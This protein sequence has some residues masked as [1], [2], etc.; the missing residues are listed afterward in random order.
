VAALFAVMTKV[1]AYAV[2][3]VYTLIFP[4][5]TPSTGTMFVDLLLP[6]AL[7][8]LVVGAVGVLG[9]KSLG[10]LVALG[11]GG[12]DGHAVHRGLAVHAD[13]HDGGA[14]LP[15]AF[16]AGDGALF[17][18]ADLVLTGRGT[19]D[20]RRALPPMPQGGLVAAL[21]F[22]GAI[23]LAGMPPLSGFLGKLLVLDAT[24]D[25]A[26]LVWPVVLV[27]SLLTIVGFA[28]AGSALFWKSHATE[29]ERGA[30]HPPAPASALPFVAVFGLLA[31][32]VALTVLAGPVTRMMAATAASLYAPQPYIDA[33]ALPAQ[34]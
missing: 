22:A 7:V 3:R 2:I 32:L 28:M 20:L 26:A 27:T 1:G 16:H 34:E 19:G 14:L 8:T 9:A 10:R 23:A 4:P 6:A 33:N 25:Q 5:Q 11:G 18:V 13:R 21:F 31:C 30:E 12:L 29:E 24:R 15:G 17:L